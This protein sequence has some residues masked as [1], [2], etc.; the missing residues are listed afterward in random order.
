MDLLEESVATTTN[1]SQTTPGASQTT[2]GGSQTSPGDSQTSPHALGGED[3]PVYVSTETWDDDV[4]KYVA[5]EFSKLT[6]VPLTYTW[7]E[8]KYEAKLH[9]EGQ[10]NGFQGNI[11]MIPPTQI[12]V[13]KEIVSLENAYLSAK[14]RFFARGCGRHHPFGRRRISCPLPQAITRGRK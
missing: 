2:P 7:T 5:E 8:Q 9:A 3:V 1:G 11:S 12:S 10:I 4:W 6:K 14:Y 13:A